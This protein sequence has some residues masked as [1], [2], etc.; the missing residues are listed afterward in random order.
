ML[1]RFRTPGFS[2]LLLWGSALVLVAGVVAFATVRIGSVEE[3]RTPQAVATEE[4]PEDYDPGATITQAQEGDVPKAARVVAG[5]F[6]LAAAGREDL[7]KAWTLAHPELKS[8]CG[9]SRTEW[10]TGNIPVQ[11]YPTEG[12]QGAGFTVNEL[13][14]DRVV[15]EVLLTPKEGSDLDPQAFYIGL[16]AVGEGAGRK[17]LVDY[18]APIAAIPVPQAG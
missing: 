16:K 7:A 14:E 18:W 2:R 15:L 1:D 9:C 8:Q 10:L 5:E 12:L 17:W 13:T 4:L 11:F 3:E 6:I